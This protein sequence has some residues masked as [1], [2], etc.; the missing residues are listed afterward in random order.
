MAERNTDYQS[1]RHQPYGRDTQPQP[2]KIRWDRWVYPCNTFPDKSER[3]GCY[4][5]QNDKNNKMDWTVYT[6]RCED[7]HD[8]ERVAECATIRKQR[9]PKSYS[10]YFDKCDTLSTRSI[11]GNASR[12]GG[13]GRSESTGRNTQGVAKLFPTRP[14]N[15]IAAIS[16]ATSRSI[17]K[18]TAPIARTILILPDGTNARTTGR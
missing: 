15:R 14:N 7:Y 1:A 5:F 16:A 18:S 13:W 10:E 4:I 6:G 9:K 3:K 12:F 17:G 2:S 11:E 8:K